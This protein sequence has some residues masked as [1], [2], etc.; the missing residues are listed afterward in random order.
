MKEYF[1]CP[2][3][4][5]AVEVKPTKCSDF[6]VGDLSGYCQ[7]CHRYFEVSFEEL[8]HFHKSLEED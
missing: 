1:P 8:D 5:E 2:Y 7:W 3:C 6:P 4:G